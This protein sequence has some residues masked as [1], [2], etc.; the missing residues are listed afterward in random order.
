M[1]MNASSTMSRKE[2]TLRSLEGIASQL[3]ILGL[4]EEA[5]KLDTARV[6]LADEVDLEEKEK[7]F[8]LLE[9]AALSLRLAGASDFATSI[10]FVLDPEPGPV[11]IQSSLRTL[12][13]PLSYVPQE[14]A[15]F[16]VDELDKAAA[17][18]VEL[19]E[20]AEITGSFEA[21]E[22]TMRWLQALGYT[23]RRGK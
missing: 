12:S 11:E 6:I 8:A 10:D 15:S 18:L 3:R 16:L 23:V 17:L 22:R 7:A 13:D 4:D 19:M 21:I 20:D 14:H 5:Q 2:K 1:A 9:D